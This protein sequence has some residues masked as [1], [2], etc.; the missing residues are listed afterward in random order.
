MN[1]FVGKAKNIN[2][3]GLGLFLNML[4]SCK[5]MVFRYLTPKER[6]ASREP[7]RGLEHAAGKVERLLPAMLAET[8][9]SRKMVEDTG[10]YVPSFSPFLGTRMPLSLSRCHNP[11]LFTPVT[12]SM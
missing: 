11:C 7:V 9:Q 6:C 12:W 3:L 10:C 4:D 5:P 1:A 8:G 2:S